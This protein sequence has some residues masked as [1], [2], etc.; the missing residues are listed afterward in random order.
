MISA[1]IENGDFGSIKKDEQLL[2]HEKNI[3]TPEALH[4]AA[5]INLLIENPWEL[6]SKK[7]TFPEHIENT[8]QLASDNSAILEVSDSIEKEILEEAF[9]IVQSKPLSSP[10]PGAEQTISD[11]Y[12]LT[13]SKFFEAESSSELFGTKVVLRPTGTGNLSHLTGSEEFTWNETANGV[14]FMSAIFVTSNQD[15]FKSWIEIRSMKWISSRKTMDSIIIEYT[16]YKDWA[17]GNIH[18]EDK[19]LVTNAVRAFGILPPEQIISI[20]EQYI[21]PSPNMPFESNDIYGTKTESLDIS[22]NGSF[23]DGGTANISY[24]LLDSS[25]GTSPVSIS[26]TWR[27]DEEKKLIIDMGNSAELSYYFTQ[28][29]NNDEFTALYYSKVYQNEIPSHSPLV[30]KKIGS[31]WEAEEVPGVYQVNSFTYELK[32]DGTG[33]YRDTSGGLYPLVWKISGTGNLIIGSYIQPFAVPGVHYCKPKTWNI[34]PYSTNDK[35]QP[36]FW[37]EWE[38]IQ[39]VNH[40]TFWVK[41]LSYSPRDGLVTNLSVTHQK[42]AKEP[43][44]SLSN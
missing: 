18:K 21:F 40:K 19:Y 28:K 8:Y 38:L 22:F 43:L 9:E 42:I 31:I 33:D 35:C 26:A 16:K 13:S 27:T 44:A 10:T 11:T 25:A 7:I 23:P 41:K 29:N 30:V 37:F 5:I 34:G 32:N 20:G 17:D 39:P 36:M 2:S 14:E 15:D 1:Q 4:I 24:P 12:L 3:H 6:K